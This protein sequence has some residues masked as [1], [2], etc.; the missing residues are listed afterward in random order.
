MSGPAVIR[1]PLAPA[2]RRSGRGWLAASLTSAQRRALT[3]L[4]L[5][6]PTADL[7]AARL[8]AY[9]TDAIPAKPHPL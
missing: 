9:L 8:A 2:A 4:T 3:Q 5:L 7:I 1:L 6:W